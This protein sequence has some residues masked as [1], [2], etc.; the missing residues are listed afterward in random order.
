MTQQ[1]DSNHPQK[2]ANQY[3]QEGKLTGVNVTDTVTSAVLHQYAYL[4]DAAG[5][6]T[7]EQIDGN[8]TG[9][10]YN[11]LNQLTGRSAGGKMV[12]SGSTGS[13]PSMVTVG[14]NAATTSYCTNFLG[15]ANVTSG[16][17]TVAVV[18]HDVEG[19]TSTNNYQVVIPPASASFTYDL[20]GNLTQD[21]T[22]SYQWDAKNE[23]TAI[24]YNAGPN[25]GNHTEFT[26]NG[27]GQRVKI[28]ERSGTVIGSGTITSTK[29]YAGNEELDGTGTVTKRYFAQGEQRIVSGVTT[30]YFYTR[31]H[32]G[33]IREMM[34]TNGTTIDAR[35][36]YDPYGRAT[37][38]SGSISCDFQYAG[39]YEH[40]TSGL[41]LTQFRAYDPNVGRWISR[42]PSG[43][44][45]GLNLYAYCA[46]S[47]IC[48][49]DSSGLCMDGP[50]L[51]G[52]QLKLS[53]ATFDQLYK[54]IE[55]ADDSVMM[56][57]ATY[58]RLIMH[59]TGPG[60]PVPYIMMMMPIGGEAEAGAAFAN[61]AKVLDH[62]A[63]HGADFGA[64]SAAEYESMAS[65]FLTGDLNGLEGTRLNGELVRF[66]PATDEFGVLKA[67]GST[68][69]TYF[70]PDPAVHG[71]PTNLDYFNSQFP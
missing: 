63:R 21:A 40:A 35:Y 46:D 65:D 34:D 54:S 27:A 50:P 8:V 53:Q 52:A 20:N 48:A 67:D 41:N 30:N 64:N 18:A 70:K 51:P 37:Q 2:W 11:S 59:V 57:D 23:V 28:V 58:E 10:T 14:G 49:T 5:N 17:N 56:D 12:F 55:M 29:Q 60:D 32:L 3:D 71:Y 13:E 31:D 39:M 22:R 62:F 68:I 25:A 24:I 69:K 6:R 47:P 1:T 26:Y 44:G 38:V 42:D 36:S 4:Y 66:N 15:L 61:E 7:S 9:A 43:E 33:S 16:T 45:S 19:N